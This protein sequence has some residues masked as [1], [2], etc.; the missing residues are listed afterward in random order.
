MTNRTEKK[1]N[2]LVIG[3]GG[4]EHALVWK[5]KQSPKAGRIYCAPGNG[6]ISEL[7]DCVPLPAGDFDGMLAFAKEKEIGLTVVGPEAPLADGIVDLFRENGLR[8]FGP[9]AAAARIES[10]KAFAKELMKKYNIPTASFE[11][12]TDADAAFGYLDTHPAPIVVKAS[13]LAAGKGAIVCM[14]DGEA[15]DAVR[16]VMVD[17]NFGD[18]GD[19]V[20][21][22]E[23]LTGEELSVFVITDGEDHVMLP[24][25]Q[26]HK[27]VY[28]GD[29]GPNTGGMG[30]Y[31][32]APLADESLLDE[33]EKTIIMPTIRA[34]KAEECPYTGLL[35]CGLMI[36]GDGPKVIE[37][38]CRFGDPE[39][40]V[41]LPLIEEDLVD[42]MNASIDET[43]AEMT[44][45]PP[46]RY[47][48]TVIMASGG[49]P[50][51][52]E[53]GKR[54][55]GID[56]VQPGRNKIIFHAGTKMQDGR[57]VTSGGRVLCMTYLNRYLNEA[58]EGA[59]Q[60]VDSVH[61]EN[62]YYRTDI[63]RKGVRRLR[64]E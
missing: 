5:L 47:A 30:A 28:D 61:F 53:K 32:P 54:I 31:A 13:G 37:Y 33:I 9:S 36:T 7:A 22:E 35:Y 12:F 15:R 52:Y 43:V 27:P 48:V 25:S 17:R 6:G 49:Y 40:Q 55:D 11:V 56:T 4:R 14:T 60:L 23:C 24:A 64:G 8:V 63:G 46:E 29:K 3:G 21:I 1:I 58:V 44:V 50:G 38:N 62:A 19:R 51:P 34:M 39:T 20:V 2:I 18:A 42:L 10:S 59:Y 16:T 26:D 45:A 57:L 41:V